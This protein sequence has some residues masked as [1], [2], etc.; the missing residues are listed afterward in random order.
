MRKSVHESQIGIMP[1]L[2]EIAVFEKTRPFFHTLKPNWMV[3]GSFLSQIA[4]AQCKKGK[5]LSEMGSRRSFP[6]VRPNGVLPPVGVIA[7][8][9]RLEVQRTRIAAV[10]AEGDMVPRLG[11]PIGIHHRKDCRVWVH[12][13]PHIR[14]GPRN[15]ARDQLAVRGPQ[16]LRGGRHEDG[17]RGRIPW[18]ELNRPDVTA[19]GPHAWDIHP[20]LPELIP[21][22]THGIVPRVNRRTGRQGGQARYRGLP[23]AARRQQWASRGRSP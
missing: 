4:R 14:D 22:G 13:R 20:A 21:P 11:A 7:L 19:A 2:T 6:P 8:P 16:G 5:Q 9:R 23:R 17:W 15:G 12:T 10:L 3:Y 1:L 18:L